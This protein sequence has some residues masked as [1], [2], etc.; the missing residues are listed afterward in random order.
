[1]VRTRNKTT[2][3]SLD[4]T[5]IE[6]LEPVCSCFNMVFAVGLTVSKP[7]TRRTRASSKKTDGQVR[8][9][10]KHKRQATKA[11][12]LLE[13][14][15]ENKPRSGRSKSGKKPVEVEKVE[16]DP[17]PA[18]DEEDNSDQ[19]QENNRN[20]FY[21]TLDEEPKR[22]RRSSI[23]GNVMPALY[24]DLRKSEEDIVDLKLDEIKRQHQIEVTQWESKVDSLEEQLKL[25]TQLLNVSL[26]FFLCSCSYFLTTESWKRTRARV[27][28]E[29]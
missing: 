12:A 22:T 15:P 17:E 4:D 9:E 23:S 5:D 7:K 1:M 24:S 13:E 2:H 29:R 10:T 21:E 28:D 6:I 27:K 14:I 18:V 19:E 3:E 20:E 8:Q 11:K 16:A 26:F 25:N